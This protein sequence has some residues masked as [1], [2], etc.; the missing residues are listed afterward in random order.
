MKKY[1]VVI[2]SILMIL[3]FP[4]FVNASEN[5]LEITVPSVKQERIAPGRDF[6][7]MGNLNLPV[8][9]GDELEIN[10]YPNF[11]NIPIRTVKVKKNSGIQY[12]DYPLLSYYGKD[13]KELLNS[14][15]PDIE[16]PKRNMGLFTEPSLKAVLSDKSFTAVFHGGIYSNDLDISKL[17][18]ITKGEYRLEVLLKDKVGKVKANQSKAIQINHAEKRILARFSPSEHFDNV[19]EFANNESS[20]IFLDPFPGY[21]S[22]SNYL[23]EFNGK[24]LFAEILPK[25]R[26]AD[27]LEYQSGLSQFIVYNVSENSATNNVEIGTLE[28]QQVINNDQR[29][30]Y[31][32]YNLG[33]IVVNGKRSK[34][35][36]FGKEDKLQL[37]RVDLDGK[38]KI[39]IDE[40]AKKTETDIDLTDGV[41]V[42]ANHNVFFNGVVTPIQNKRDELKK[43]PDNHYEIKNRINSLEYTFYNE[44]GKILLKKDFSVGLSRIINGKERS[45][46]YEF[47]N[48]LFIPNEWKGKKVLVHIDGFDKNHK[49]VAGTHEELHLEVAN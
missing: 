3:V 49:L 2:F 18:G 31:Y 29:I 44:N 17:E 16:I 45:S 37:T 25:W 13:R 36:P 20:E 7:I 23:A 47:R 8:N 48:Q 22:P 32:Y 19:K 34:I 27:L 46:I 4:Q 38:D 11:Y 6:Y 5:K 43:Y 28:E 24:N 30:K 26:L 33:D 41:L 15:M 40:V 39:E 12:V 9:E 21:W 42:K 1:S 35:V 10:L 14:M